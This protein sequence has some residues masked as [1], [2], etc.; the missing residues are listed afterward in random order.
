MWRLA[1]RSAIFLPN[2]PL[3]NLAGTITMSQYT[4]HIDPVILA[5][6]EQ[7]DLID[8][9]ILALDDIDFEFL[10]AGRPGPAVEILEAVVVEESKEDLATYHQCAERFAMSVMNRRKPV[11]KRYP[12]PA[13]PW[14]A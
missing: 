11:C 3:A 12:L 14:A 13:D 1:A 10:K 9:V 8:E 4:A 5:T 6:F 2:L 7:T